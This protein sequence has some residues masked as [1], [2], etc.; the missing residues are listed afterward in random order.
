[1]TKY[2]FQEKKQDAESEAQKPIN[3]MCIY[4]YNII[5]I[6]FWFDGFSDCLSVCPLFEGFEK[7]AKSSQTNLTN[8]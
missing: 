5:M 2:K 8:L 3:N 7:H 1:M 4:I 6:A